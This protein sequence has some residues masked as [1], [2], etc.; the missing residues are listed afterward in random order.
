MQLRRSRPLPPWFVQV[1]G[2]IEYL[3]GNGEVIESVN[4]DTPRA[5]RAAWCREYA[6]DPATQ[7]LG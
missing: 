5:L 6:V 7:L 3:G 2:M 1:T 4:A